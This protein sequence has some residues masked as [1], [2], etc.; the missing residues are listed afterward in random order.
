MNG[1]ILSYR[2]GRFQEAFTL[3]QTG[4]NLGAV[5]NEMAHVHPMQ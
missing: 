2:A 1:G 5:G 3:Y 4:C